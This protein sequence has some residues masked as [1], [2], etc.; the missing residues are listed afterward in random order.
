MLDDRKQ[1]LWS[2]EA[3][4]QMKGFMYFA[5]PMKPCIPAA[6]SWV[7]WNGLHALGDPARR[8]TPDVPHPLSPRPPPPPR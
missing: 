5:N 3:R 4:F 1:I 2:H 8:K 7:Y 6:N